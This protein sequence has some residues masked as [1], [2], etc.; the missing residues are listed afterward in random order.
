[1]I[2]FL[3]RRPH[4]YTVRLY[5]ERRAPELEPHVRLVAWEDVLRRTA[6]PP[7][8]WIFSDLDRLSAAE[9]AFAGHVH[10]ALEGAGPRAR[11]V[12]DPR[13][14][15][16]RVDLLRTLHERGINDFRA[17]QPGRADR[18]C[19]FPVFVREA[20][21][22][23]GSLTPLLRSRG[24]LRAAVRRLRLRGY[25]RSELLVVEFLDCR[26]A[27]GLYRKY[28]AF[29]VGSEILARSLGGSP[30]WVV[31]QG[32]S[33]VDPALIEEERRYVIDNPHERPLREVFD[34]AAV[35]YGRVDYAVVDGRVQVWEI[36]LNP[37]IGPSPRKG[38]RPPEHER[39]RPLREPAR[40]HFH[41]RFRAALLALDDA[42]T[43]DD[44][45][46]PRAPSLR[47]RAR[48]GA[49]GERARRW[50]G[51]AVDGLWDRVRGGRT[52]G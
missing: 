21:E 26:S 16:R 46:L 15:L 11:A 29:R 34:L 47:A 24:E 42:G 35:E 12:N 52:R 30:H 23:H 7:G 10:D 45:A 41:E 1:M 8:T 36:N 22:H 27:D 49:F 44:I 39:L 51:G 38:P 18:G 37:T 40:S 33:A 20:D 17:F 43:G 5:L 50:S 19:R 6:L 25:R 9:R 28:A 32:D 3:L 2:H 48:L 13:S 14:T 31:K 4:F